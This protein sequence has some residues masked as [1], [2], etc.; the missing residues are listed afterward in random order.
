MALQAFVLSGLPRVLRGSLILKMCLMLN[1][2]KSGDSP[3]LLERHNMNKHSNYDHEKHLPDNRMQPN[4]SGLNVWLREQIIERLGNDAA[5][6]LIQDAAQYKEKRYIWMLDRMAELGHTDLIE[7]Y[8]KRRL[9]FE[10]ER[11]Y[12]DKEQKLRQ[13]RDRL[14]ETSD[15]QYATYIRKQI[16]KCEKYLEE[17]KP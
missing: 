16:A 14:S 11:R 6:C 13:W 15:P 5:Q 7:E 10:A 8:H 9:A 12:R 17:R 4:E 1:S 3:S 2:N